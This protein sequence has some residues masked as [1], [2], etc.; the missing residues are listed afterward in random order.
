VKVGGRHDV[1]DLLLDMMRRKVVE[2][3]NPLHAWEGYKLARY[4]NVPIPEWVLEYLDTCAVALGDGRDAEDALG[5]RVKGGHSKFR[6]METASRDLGIFARLDFLLQITPDDLI[7]PD[8]DT[9][10]LLRIE[11]SLKGESRF[12]R[13]VQHVARENGL[14]AKTTRDIYY[15]LK[16]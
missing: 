6:Q 8:S 12:D 10:R 1:A 16:R 2:E 15:R 3:K 9:I 7:D 4:L 11:S 14:S 5:L 13:I